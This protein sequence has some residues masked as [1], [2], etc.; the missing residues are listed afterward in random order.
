MSSTVSPA[1]PVMGGGRWSLST[2]ILVGLALGALTGLFFGEPTAVLQPLADIYVRLMQMTVL[3]YLVLTLVAGLGQLDAGEARRLG[4]RGGLLLMGLIGLALAVIGAATLAFPRYESATFFSHAMAEPR[5]AFGLA[6]LYFPE[7][8]FN[9][10]A[11]AIVPGVVLFSAALGIALIGV[12]G[13]EG[14]LQNL[15]VIERAVVRVTHFVFS[16]TPVGVFAITAVAA[17]T[18]EPATLVRLEAY[19]LTFG[20]VALL[21]TFVVLPAVVMALTP[22]RYADIVSATRDAL[23]TA[24]ITSS[25][26]I[27]LP[28]LMERTSMLLRQHGLGG[29]HADS[30]IKVLVPVAFTFPNPGR[31][32]TLLFVPF[33][34]WLAGEPLTGAAYATLFAAG[35]PAYF[36]KAQ[37][38]LP[39]LM[40]LLAVPYSYFQLYIPSAVV[41]GRFDAMASAMSL[42]A[43]ALLCTVVDRAALRRNLR[44]LALH[45]LVVVVA[46]AATLVG[47]RALLATTLDTSYRSDRLLTGQATRSPVR[48]I[49]RDDVPV[50]D[51]GPGAVAGLDRILR[52]GYLRVG[53]VRDQ[54][55]FTFLNLRG[56][57]VG[58]DVELAGA[59]AHDLGLDAVEFVPAGR[60]E[61]TALLESG[62]IDMV[63][64]V[65]YLSALLPQLRMAGPL[66]EGVVGLVTPGD[67]RHD[68]ARLDNLQHATRLRIGVTAGRTGFEER[69]RARLPQVQ[70]EFVP[71]DSPQDYFMGRAPHL[72]AV[73][74]LAQAGAAWTLLHPQ[75]AVTVPQP[76]PLKVPVGIAL[77]RQDAE[78]AEFVDRWLVLQQ[79]SGVIAAAYDYWIL[80]KGIERRQ[81][82][83]SILRDVLGWGLDAKPVE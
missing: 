75:F 58:M 55:P 1:R 10:L 21:I 28:L 51:A 16:L 74:M 33:A 78:L 31:L 52:R 6:E 24:F 30:T 77:R 69:L 41:T 14:V 76:D 47:L 11:N 17:G 57:L 53:F 82:R 61:I 81:L 79:S 44:R 72:D 26:F 59:L 50:G 29:E 25:V 35:V 80:G 15:R 36:A 12:D 18:L 67:R 22:L 34:A 62:S 73:A 23:L 20:A 32:L 65:P 8:P 48:V 70:F 4:V 2:Q 46:V 9:A 54:P 63:M 43:L 39:F 3:P 83:W 49:V 37:V 40:D 56:D 38:A 27:V 60:Q 68:F 42:F 5:Q 7:N 66:F 64:T 19:F 13:K 71:L 45:G